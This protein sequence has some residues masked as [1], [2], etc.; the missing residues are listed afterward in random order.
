MFTISENNRVGCKDGPPQQGFD[1]KP[2][3][4][5]VENLQGIRLKER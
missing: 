2:S 5:P 3:A 4:A 1:S